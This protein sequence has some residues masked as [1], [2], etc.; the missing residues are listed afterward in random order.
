MLQRDYLMKI[1]QD[2]FDAIAKLILNE[3]EKLTEKQRQIVAMY[4]M[5]NHDAHFFR[6]TDIDTI[7]LVM[8]ELDEYMIR[9]EMLAEIYYADAKF[10]T[11]SAEVKSEL[12]SKSLHLYMYVDERSDE[13]SLRRQERI[14]ELKLLIK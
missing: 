5:L 1:L 7:M 6:T 8:S 2:L 13:F 4:T 12:L 10:Y 11:G 3:E 14:E 9:L